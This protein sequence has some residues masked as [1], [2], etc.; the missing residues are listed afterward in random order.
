MTLKLV[1]LTLKVPKGSE[2]FVKEIVCRELNEFVTKTKK[3]TIDEVDA[4]IR[5]EVKLIKEANGLVA[6]EPV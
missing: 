1:N 3:A 2:E 6:V 4:E 5:S